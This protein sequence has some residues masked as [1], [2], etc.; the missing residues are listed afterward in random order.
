MFVVFVVLFVNRYR[1]ETETEMEKKER[2][3]DLHKLSTAA[4]A[5]P[6]G[7]C[8]GA[9][10]HLHSVIVLLQLQLQ[11]AVRCWR[12]RLPLGPSHSLAVAH[13]IPIHSPR[14]KSDFFDILHPSFSSSSSSSSNGRLE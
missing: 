9:A 10:A 13:R 8:N 3:L 2:G 12:I 4:V 11:D 1:K 6:L 5:T 14:A 7:Q